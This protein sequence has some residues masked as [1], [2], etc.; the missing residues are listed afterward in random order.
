[1]RHPL[2]SIPPAKRL[3]VF[4]PLLLLTFAVMIVFRIVGP[5]KPNIVDYELAGSAVRSQ[6]II[7]AW[8][9]VDRIHAG[10]NLGIDYLYMPLYSS[11][12]A[13]ALV[14]A[15]GVFRSSAA[16]S[17]GLLL[18][19]GL[20]LAA[21]FDAIE[22]VALI[23]ILFNAA[24]IDPWPPLAAVCA[25]IKFALIAIGLVYVVVGLAARVIKRNSIQ[26]A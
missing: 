10:F 23:V 1:M 13:L 26:S 21:C 5:D 11:L 25:A 4:V 8:S 2:E 16:S 3:R 12:I 17:I 18:A 9:P 24:A 7:D 15:A 20:W 22:N 19:W 6:A 14:W